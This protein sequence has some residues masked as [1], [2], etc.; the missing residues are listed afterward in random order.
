MD[1]IKKH[2]DQFALAL[3]A[4]VLLACSVLLIQRVQGFGGAFSAA[5][6]NPK[7]K[8][9]VPPLVL[10]SI[11]AAR[12][13]LEA[14]PQWRENDSR[15]Q[16]EDGKTRKRGSLFVAD[17][18]VIENNL[19]KPP[20]GVSFYKDSFSGKDIP[21]GWFMDHRLPLL[22]P[23][24]RLQDPD[25]DGFLNEDEWRAGTDPNKKESH[26]PYY[27]KL[28]VKQFIRTPFRMVFKA[29]DYEPKHPERLPTCSFQINTLD[30]KQPSEFLKLTDVISNT[31]FKLEKFHYKTQPN[32][33]TGEQD[34]VSE[35][36]L[37]NI[38]TGELVVLVYNRIIDSPNFSMEFIYK[39]ENPPRLIP[40]KKGG[41]F[42]LKPGTQADYKLIDSNEG[43]AQ[44]QTPDG[45]KIEILPDPRK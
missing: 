34:D 10:S 7:P 43:K 19:P 5:L 37:R 23:E 18:Y 6:A 3:L 1:W 16:E 12:K 40:V 17:R 42:G 41:N 44:I 4:L 14:P 31:K 28:F 13:A 2:Y 24:V 36:T 38:E 32:K 26:P 22:D 8:E 15:A 39:W 30:L 29:H 25:K 20:G 45:Q 27:T 11:E 9:D 21:N 35:L 33:S